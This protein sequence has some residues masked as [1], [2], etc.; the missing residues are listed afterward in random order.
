MVW[1]ICSPKKGQGLKQ[2]RAKYRHSSCQKE[3]EVNVK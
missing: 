3:A 2:I 1:I